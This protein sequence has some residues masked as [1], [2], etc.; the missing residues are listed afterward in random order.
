MPV[1]KDEVLWCY[2]TLLGREP[3][4]GAAASSHESHSDFRALV[5]SFTT[6]AEYA[7]R[8]TPVTPGAQSR[9]FMATDMPPLAIDL[10]ANA[11]QLARCAQKIKQAWQHLGNERAHF[12]VLTSDEF[13]PEN[14][15]GS[16]EQFWSSGEYEAARAVK[17]LANHGIEHLGSRDCVEYGCGVGRITAALAKRFRQVHAYDISAPHLAYARARATETE[18]HN[19]AFHE[20][21]DFLK[22]AIAPCDVFY[23]VIVFQHNPPPVMIE[24]IR[25]ALAALRPGGIA[26]FQLPVYIV[27]YRFDLEEWLTTEHA[28]DMQMHCVPQKSVFD[29]IERQDCELLEVREDGAAGSPDTIL[30]NTFVVRR[31]RRTS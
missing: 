20:C 22:T 28:L 15:S 14:F 13:L 30:S 6:S 10:A 18:Q 31:A 7:R 12:S 17:I 24:L 26:L 19:I 29:M 1:T 4:S 2:R 11:D 23:S 5:E 9:A 16:A 27:S 8:K 3:E 25:R 21:T